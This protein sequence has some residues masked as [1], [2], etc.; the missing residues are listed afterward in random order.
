LVTHHFRIIGGSLNAWGYRQ[1][2]LIFMSLIFKILPENTVYINSSTSQLDQSESLP[3]QYSYKIL[4]GNT[5]Y[6]NSS[7][8]QL[9][10]IEHLPAQYSYIG[11]T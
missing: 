11:R 3:A 5:V 10:Q 8:L 2:T 6:I 4:P 7:T 9:D 1:G